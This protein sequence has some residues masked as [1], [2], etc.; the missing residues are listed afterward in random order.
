MSIVSIVITL[1]I[2]LF[3][4]V[5]H[6]LSHGVVAD[7]LGD[8]TARYMGRLTLNPI[9]HLD[10]FASILLPLFL[11]LVG[12]PIIFG[13][14]KPVPVNFQNL[15]DP[16][17]GMALVSLAGPLSNFVLA[18]AFA[19]PIR[20]GLIDASAGIGF[21]ILLQAVVLNLVLGVFNLIPV[22]PLDGSK[23]LV[24]FFDDQLMHRFLSLERYGF[25]III[26]LLYLRII[27]L[28]LLPIVNFL[29]Q[30]FLGHPVIQ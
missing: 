16:K 6:E 20:V 22:P 28:V 3:S 7:R 25:L 5:I 14:A 27:H 18:F 9:P 15:R 8:S 11:F 1:I 23:I 4:V 26:L 17:K 10:I 13:A 21:D 24:S 12:S 2:L 29:S 30:I 19:I